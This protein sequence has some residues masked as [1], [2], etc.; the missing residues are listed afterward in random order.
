MPQQIPSL[1][2]VGEDASE[3]RR[4]QQVKVFLG[5]VHPG[6]VH[7]AFMQS[8]L[9]LL[10]EPTHT[11]VVAGNGSGPLICRARNELLEAFLASD[12]EAFLSV[13]TDISF[14]P[15]TLD[16]LVGADQPIV[17]AHYKGINSAGTFPVALLRNSQGLYDKATYKALRGR[18][19][20]KKVD[21][22]GMGFTLIRREVVQA[23]GVG[24]LWPFAEILSDK[25]QALG[26]DATFCLRAKEKGF[27]AH[28][29][30]DAH[31][32]HHKTTQ[33]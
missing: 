14:D 22:V 9:R 3:L 23:L 10:H 31:V 2:T 8:V 1:G 5:Y 15:G 25:G 26:E 24:V 4:Q 12:A 28:L 17:G 7:S 13:D 18:K 21:A 29:L 11:V 32:G 27:D 30:L 19:G 33:Y 16:Q 6:M 20:L